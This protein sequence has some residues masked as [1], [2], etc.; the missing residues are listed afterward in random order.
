MVLIL[1]DEE[2]LKIFKGKVGRLI[3][4][5]VRESGV[6]KRRMNLELFKLMK[7]EDIVKHMKS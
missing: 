4:G 2:Q 6:L 5:G 3:F 7:N 1:N